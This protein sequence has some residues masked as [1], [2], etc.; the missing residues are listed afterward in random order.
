MKIATQTNNVVRSNVGEE[1]EF[2][3]ESNAKM[4]R[5]LS[6]TMYQNKIGSMVR[7]VSCNAYDSHVEA[8][9]ADVPFTIHMPDEMEPFFSVRDYGI[10]LDDNGVRSVFSTYGRSSK[11]NNNAVIG[12]FGLGSKTPFAYTDAFVIIAMKDGVRRQYSAFINERG[13]PAVT[14]LDEAPTTED[15]GVEIQV[16]VVN[17]NDIRKFIHETE[18]Q[19]A[20]FPVKPII[21][22]YEFDMRYPNTALTGS[23]Y[24]NCASV[25]VGTGHDSLRGVWAVQGVVGYRVDVALVCSNI[26]HENGEF[27]K[28][29][30]DSALIQFD[31]GLLEVTASREGISYTPATFA[32]FNAKLDAARSE[33]TDKVAAE[34]ANIDSPWLKAMA[35]SDGS[36][37]ARYA[38]LTGT[39]F[40]DNNY[41][42][43]PNGYYLDL[44]RVANIDGA[45][46]QDDGPVEVQHGEKVSDEK[47]LANLKLVFKHYSGDTVRRQYRYRENGY[48]RAARVSPK[49]H[50]VVR[51]TSDKPVVRMREYLAAMSHG[52]AIYMLENRDGSLVTPAQK[53]AVLA[54]IGDGFTNVT[55]LSSVDLPLPD[56]R[57][58]VVGYKAPTGYTYEKGDDRRTARHWV[59]ETG[60]LAE[61]EE[62]A[63]YVTV[64]RHAINLPQH[65]E[66]V[67]T[68]ADQG[69]LD[70]P[71]AAIRHRDVAK[72]DTAKWIPLGDKAQEI[73]DSIKSNVSFLNAYSLSHFSTRDVIDS[74]DNNFVEI[75]KSEVA[76]GNLP[77]RNPLGR[78]LRVASVRDKLMARYKNRGYNEF[79]ALV[80]QKAALDHDARMKR[81]SRAVERFKTN[82]TETYPML[83]GV[84]SSW[85]YVDG[86]SV[87]TLN[88][89]LA[90]HALEYIHYVN[91]KA[92]V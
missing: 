25:T 86:R 9:K 30:A 78:A 28:M 85:G 88:P 3:I 58:G 57:T 37:L 7:E 51:D 67:F 15:N 79:T 32:S 22:N 50:I 42:K 23:G 64:D 77:S 71:I 6:D 68:L 91:A 83:Q 12:A 8:G 63:Y 61:W 62:G 4:F 2:T 66:L 46:P 55:D 47:L 39:A 24:L 17:T 26:K 56:A 13:R 1:T 49:L 81:I 76:A 80:I 16:P 5:V 92:G 70:R 41:Y 35:L 59:K 48:G 27:L 65:Y 11:E 19:L 20:F 82:I 74:V 44:E 45:A 33:L 21:T 75:L 69:L 73:V 43:T 18:Q 54:R 87:R 90:A 53:A 89:K 38:R 84:T 36:A 14:L 31:M 40:S 34:I 72:L 10:G 60:K 52:Q 29:V